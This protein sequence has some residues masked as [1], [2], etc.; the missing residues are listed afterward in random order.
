MASR[1]KKT[2][3]RTAPR[4]RKQPVGGGAGQKLLLGLAG[5]VL[6]LCVASI[7]QGFY[8]R[9]VDG[10]P[11][12]QFRVE[13]LNG[14]GIPGLANAGKRCLHRRGIDVI[15]AR[16]ADRFNYG[17]SIIMQRRPE[18]DVEALGKLIGCDNIVEQ[19]MENSLVDAT[20]ILGADYR[21]LDLDW[22]LESDLLE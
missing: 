22:E 10:G 14:A 21:D 8:F 12:S 6:V 3:R 13:V 1:K 7:T 9:T 16:N 18:A 19:R 11:G 20:I 5:V 4:R 17:E 15:D 2:R